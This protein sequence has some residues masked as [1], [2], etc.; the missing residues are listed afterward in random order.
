MIVYWVILLTVGFVSSTG[1]LCLMLYRQG[2]MRFELDK[3]K[4]WHQRSDL[5]AQLLGADLRGLCI[6]A[7]QHMGYDDIFL[8]IFN[9]FERY[10]RRLQDGRE[11]TTPLQ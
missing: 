2:H 7:R 9:A 8:G 4:M 5:S 11:E 6:K 1:W 10:E 3:L